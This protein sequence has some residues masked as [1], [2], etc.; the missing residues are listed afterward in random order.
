MPRTRYAISVVEF[1]IV[2]VVCVVIAIVMVP[3][4]TT[5]AETRS[6]ETQLRQALQCLRVAI[7][8]YQQ[9]HG[10]LPGAARDG[11]NAAE[12]S[13]AFVAQLTQYSDKDGVVANEPTSRFRYGPYLRGGIPGCP[14]ASRSGYCDVTM[15]RGEEVVDAGAA[16]KTGWVFDLATGQIRTK[17]NGADGQGRAFATY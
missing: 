14:V 3:R 10:V 1:I 17:S 9:D 2:A 15:M 13:A 12:T 7:E 6:D 11:K 4:L 16:E 5:A 8:R